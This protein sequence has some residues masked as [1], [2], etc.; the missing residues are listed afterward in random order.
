MNNVTMRPAG[1]DIASDAQ[2]FAEF[3]EMASDGLFTRLMGGR[4]ETILAKMFA[5]PANDNSYQYTR[6][7]M[8]GDQFAGMINAFTGAQKKAN[9]R[10]VGWLYLRYC[11]WRMPRLFAV[12]MKFRRI[13][14]FMDRVSDDAYYIQMV[15]V[16]PQFRGRGLSRL[17]L[18]DAE[19]AAHQAGCVSLAL[20]V[21]IHNE[22]A[23]AAYTSY[24]F[25]ISASSPVVQSGQDE[26]SVHRMVKTLPTKS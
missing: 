1:S 8:V 22:I 15:G 25:H 5:H 19:Q 23:I 21:D 7:I 10:Q 16:Y 26:V 17:I 12:G 11:T 20:D 3:A 13:L 18:A 24:G 6:F 2:A 14:E 4:A 9:R